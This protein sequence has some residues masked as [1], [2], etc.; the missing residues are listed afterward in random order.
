MTSLTLA[1]SSSAFTNPCWCHPASSTPI[2]SSSTM[3][4]LFIFCSAYNGQQSIGTPA[5]TPSSTEFHPQCVTNAPVA[6]CWSTATCGAHSLTTRPRPLVLSRNPS[7]RSACRSG[8]ALSPNSLSGLSPRGARTTQRNRW[9]DLSRPTAISLSCVSEW[10]LDPTLPKHRNTTLSSGCSSSHARHA[11]HA[12]SSFVSAAFST[13]G[14]TQ[15][16]GGI[17][18]LLSAR[19]CGSLRA[20]T[21]RASSDANVFTSMPPASRFLLSEFIIAL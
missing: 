21:A 5:M 14:P 1:S 13:S 2:R 17:L 10:L 20:A 9:P 12:C 3:S 6:L 15:Y 16:T 8:S 18:S 11:S 7:G 4:T 19:K